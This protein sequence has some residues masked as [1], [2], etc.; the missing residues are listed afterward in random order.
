MIEFHIWVGGFLETYGKFG[1][2]VYVY[3]IIYL[4]KHGLSIPSNSNRV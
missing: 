3:I 1:I 2:Y 4:Y